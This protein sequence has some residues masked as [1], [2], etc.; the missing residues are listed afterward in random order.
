MAQAEEEAYQKAMMLA[1]AQSERGSSASDR[2]KSCT[3]IRI[4]VTIAA[5]VGFILV[6]FA[7]ARA[8]PEESE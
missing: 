5:I 7:V 8:N 6:L 2:R 4:F 3:L 1:Q